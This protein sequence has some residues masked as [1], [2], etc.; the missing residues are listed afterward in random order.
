MN[1]EPKR[2]LV[3]GATGYLGGYVLK[4]CKHQGHWVRALV[5]SAGKLKGLETEPDE[6]FEGQ[7]TEPESL[8]NLCQGIEVVFSS[9]GITRQKDGPTFR[10]VDYQGNMNLLQ[11]AKRAGVKKFVY[12]SVL[13]GPNLMHLD[14][15]K[16]HEDFVVQL[17]ASGLEYTIIRPT[18]YF[19][20]ME[21]I[22]KMAEKGRIWMIGSGENKMNPIHGADLAVVCV[23][24]I[25]TGNTEIDA[26]GPEILT[27]RQIAEK[28]FS[29][30]GKP[31]RI[32]SVP[33]WS[34]KAFVW[35]TQRFSRHQGQLLAF[36]T[37]MMLTDMVAPAHGRIKLGVH[38]KNT[39]EKTKR[40]ASCPGSTA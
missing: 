7:V 17:K 36:F 38:Y 15:V 6:I 1:T 4:E 12:V 35:L 5:R 13:N 33:S 2:V 22:L 3:A 24:S 16:A 19:S 11:E 20:D 26:G 8:R 25:N 28:A 18:G 31:A 34:M 29:A 23:D 14:I 37:T 39:Q 10:D 27:Q 9:I 30:V 32:S 21:E 40:R